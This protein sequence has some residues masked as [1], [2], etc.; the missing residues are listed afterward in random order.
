[1]LSEARQRF[2]GCCLA[3]ISSVTFAAQGLF[4]KLLT[5]VYATEILFVR[6]VTTVVLLLPFLCV[7]DFALLGDRGVDLLWLCVGG[8]SAAGEIAL[9]YYAMQLMPY[10]DVSAIIFS[11]FVLVMFFAWVFLRESCGA[12][13]IIVTLITIAG[14]VLVAHPEAIF[15][16]VSGTSDA[17]RSDYFASRL[18]GTGVALLSCC[19]TVGVFL[20]ARRVCHIHYAVLTF[21]AAFW[22]T[23]MSATI[24][25]VVGQWTIPANTAEW[26]Y[27]LGVTTF[28][29]VSILFVYQALRLEEAGAVSMVRTSEITFS[30]IMQI[31]FMGQYPNVYAA[32]GAVIISFTSVACGLRAWLRTRKKEDEQSRLLAAAK[33]GNEAGDKYTEDAVRPYRDDDGYQSGESTPVKNRSLNDDDHDIGKSL[34]SRLRTCFCQSE[35]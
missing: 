8:V 19:C 14:I 3:L 13:E 22:G 20:S 32:V 27:L 18:A 35:N 16:A 33:D 12:F 6:M 17:A 10:A 29:F 21:H 9:H 7:G 34:K 25:C 5:D 30:Y 31:I 24:T 15:A 11:G 1:M 26:L 2:L 28:G 23:I 4:F